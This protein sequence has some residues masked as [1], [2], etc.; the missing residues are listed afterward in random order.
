VSGG[1]TT[2]IAAPERDRVDIFS[3]H[4]AGSVLLCKTSRKTFWFAGL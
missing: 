4:R 3:P 1:F 2:F